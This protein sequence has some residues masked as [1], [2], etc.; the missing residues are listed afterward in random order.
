M[1]T[2]VIVSAL[3]CILSALVFVASLVLRCVNART[4]QRILHSW[5]IHAQHE[6]AMLDQLADIRRRTLAQLEDDARQRLEVGMDPLLAHQLQ[7]LEEQAASCRRLLLEVEAATARVLA[8]Q[9][10]TAQ[11]TAEAQRQLESTLPCERGRHSL[12]VAAVPPPP[13]PDG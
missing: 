2:A 3:A 8:Q 6:S 10:L 7:R 5:L 13:Q 11:G 9:Q 4:W 1:S 12:P